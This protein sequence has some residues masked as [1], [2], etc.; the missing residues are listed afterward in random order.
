MTCICRE[1]KYGH[2]M[3]PDGR[4]TP[5]GTVWCAKRKIA[6]GQNRNMPCFF[7]LVSE[8]GRRCQDCKW[9]RMLKPSGETPALGKMWCEKRHF[10]A[11]KLRTM[12]CFES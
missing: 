1:C 4:R 5:S 9:A 8:K 7:P 6:M 2:E 10:E 12:E 3:T 11:N